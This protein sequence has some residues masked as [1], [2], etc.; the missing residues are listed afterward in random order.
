MS[1]LDK[2]VE[3]PP[4]DTDLLSFPI[5]LYVLCNIILCVCVQPPVAMDLRQYLTAAGHPHPRHTDV[6]GRRARPAR[7]CLDFNKKS[8]IFAY[9]QWVF[10]MGKKYFIKYL[11]VLKPFMF[12][13]FLVS[14]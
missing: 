5:P 10:C 2:A 13:K 11:F 9:N 8:R 6:T 12:G 4:S 7:I 3:A 1:N 14:W